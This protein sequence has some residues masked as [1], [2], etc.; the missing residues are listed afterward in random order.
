[1][2]S[3]FEQVGST[4]AV[5]QLGPSGA[6]HGFVGAGDGPCVLFCTGA[7]HS[8]RFVYARDEPAIG[9]GVGVEVETTEPKEAY[10]NR[11]EWEPGVPFEL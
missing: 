5:L 6:A 11:P 4:L 10:A 8:R 3:W 1:M 7:Q 2:D 9:H